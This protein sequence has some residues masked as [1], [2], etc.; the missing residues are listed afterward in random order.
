VNPLAGGRSCKPMGRRT[1]VWVFLFLAVLVPF[2]CG[3]G[4]Q[5][6][7]LIAALRGGDPHLRIDAVNALGRI[8]AIH[9]VL[10]GPIEARS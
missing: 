6:G 3:Q 7:Q 1:G 9:A 2:G 10:N 5:V 4:D 8:G